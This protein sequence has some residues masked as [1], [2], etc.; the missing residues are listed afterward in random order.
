MLFRNYLIILDGQCT[1]ADGCDFTNVS[2]RYI[3]YL[4]KKDNIILQM[5]NDEALA[6]DMT[7]QGKVW[8]YITFHSNFSR[9]F[10]DKIWNNVNL[11]RFLR[12][13]K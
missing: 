6:Y 5:V 9:A 7:K 2:C 3:S 13:L 4:S 10:L 1:Y 8:G 11:I 12:T